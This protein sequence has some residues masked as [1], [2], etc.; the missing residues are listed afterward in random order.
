MLKELLKQWK[1]P[2]IKDGSAVNNQEVKVMNRNIMLI[3]PNKKCI[4]NASYFYMFQAGD[5]GVL[6]AI[7]EAVQSNYP[8]KVL[9]LYDTKEQTTFA[10]GL[11]FDAMKNDEEYF[12]FPHARDIDDM[13]NYAR[14]HRSKV[15]NRNVGHGGS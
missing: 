5:K 14:Q 7:P 15:T 11:M 10:L 3:S 9:A 12:E 6:G 1:E 2:E 8:S 4:Y 13:M